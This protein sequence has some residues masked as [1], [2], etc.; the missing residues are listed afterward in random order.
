MKSNTRIGRVN[1]AIF[2]EMSQ[3]IR[4]ELKDPRISAMTS[5]IRVETTPD[6]KY[7]KVYVSVFGGAEEKASVMKG[8]K[9]ANG[10]IRRQIAQRVNL[11]I[12]PELIFKLDESAEYAVHMD[13]LMAQITQERLQ[14]EGVSEEEALDEEEDGE[15]DERE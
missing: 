6:L 4:A 8:L 13:Q 1:D 5:V 11:R 9:N 10:F 2:K 3:I 15:A 7:C 14:R 12:T